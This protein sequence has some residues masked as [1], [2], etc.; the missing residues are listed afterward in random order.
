M[1]FSISM[2]LLKDRVDQF[3]LFSFQHGKI[4]EHG[5]MLYFKQYLGCNFQTSKCFIPIA[6]TL[7]VSSY[8]IKIFP[9]T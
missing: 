7:T 5:A 1:F 2:S 9:R 8:L 4:T 6:R 3:I